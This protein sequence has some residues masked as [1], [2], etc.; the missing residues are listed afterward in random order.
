MVFDWDSC[1]FS[2]GIRDYSAVPIIVDDIPYNSPPWIVDGHF[3]AIA[4][5]PNVGVIVE[6]TGGYVNRYP[7]GTITTLD[8]FVN[9]AILPN[10]IDDTHRYVNPSLYCSNPTGAWIQAVLLE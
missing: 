4:T 1:L 3:K 8:G 9:P 10:V 6:S 5:G 7:I 2:S